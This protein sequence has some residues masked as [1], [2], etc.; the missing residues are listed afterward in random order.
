MNMAMPPRDTDIFANIESCDYVNLMGFDDINDIMADDLSLPETPLLERSISGSGRNSASP[1]SVNSNPTSL[2]DGTKSFPY[3][4][5]TIVSDPNTDDVVHWLPCG[6]R[7][8]ICKKDEFSTK[9]IP[10]NFGGRS[11]GATKYTSFTRRLKRWNFSRVP[12]GREMGAYYHKEFLRD[13]PE[14]AMKIIYPPMAAKSAEGGG[15]VGASSG[16]GGSSGGSKKKKSPT[17]SSKKPYSKARRRASTG[18]MPGNV[19][20]LD[21]TPVPFRGPVNAFNEDEILPLPDLEKRNVHD[22]LNDMKNWLSDADADFI[23]MEDPLTNP[24]VVESSS[25]RLEGGAENLRTDSPFTI[26]GTA[27]IDAEPAS[28]VSNSSSQYQGQQNAMLPLP[29]FSNKVISTTGGFPNQA[30]ADSYGGIMQPSLIQQMLKMTPRT[31]MRRHSIQ[32]TRDPMPMPL[33]HPGTVGQSSSGQFNSSGMN[34]SFNLS[35]KLQG[36]N[37]GSTQAG[38]CSASN[39]MGFASNNSVVPN[40]FTSNN[41]VGMLPNTVD[42]HHQN[43]LLGQHGSIS[44]IGGS[45]NN[46]KRELSIED[47]TS[48]DPFT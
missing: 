23:K 43:S 21:I 45:A 27:T 26:P 15:K 29:F 1:P 31:M 25:E 19:D 18:C 37:F 14:L 39:M 46:L 12:A 22:E 24:L 47:L 34:S 2:D 28:V 16:T 13:D 33:F 44:G 6:T 17:L 30:Q 8:V 11:G 32:M 4:L 5:H 35:S 41:N 10:Q 3:I 42:L 38:M 48:L 9:I 36:T 7:F 40:K 20:I